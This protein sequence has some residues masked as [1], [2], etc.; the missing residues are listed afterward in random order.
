MRIA[1]DWLEEMFGRGNWVV[2]DTKTIKQIQLDAMKDGAIR[3]ARM[4]YALH[5]RAT[6]PEMVEFNS[7]VKHTKDKIEHCIREAAENWSTK[8]L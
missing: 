6:T 3:S 5:I 1:E 7:G 2:A 4:I 8:D